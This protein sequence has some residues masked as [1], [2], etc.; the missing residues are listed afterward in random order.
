MKAAAKKKYQ[1]F[2]FVAYRQKDFP[3]LTSSCLPPHPPSP[4]PSY[5]QY[6]SCVQVASDDSG[7]VGLK[8]PE[9]QK[10]EFFAF[11]VARDS[12][13]W[14]SRDVF[15]LFAAAVV[16]VFVSGFVIPA[17]ARHYRFDVWHELRFLM[18]R[19]RFCHKEKRRRRRKK[20]KRKRRK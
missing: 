18:D 13:K 8:L 17:G 10:N 9:I 15:V 14:W 7:Q 3:P 1:I 5:W 19:A 2:P 4:P 16:V 20:K 6:L 11:W 12:W